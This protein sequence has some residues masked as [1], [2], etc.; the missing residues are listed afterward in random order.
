MLKQS[1]LKTADEILYCTVF[2]VRQK[3]LISA[4]FMSTISLSFSLL[5]TEKVVFFHQ[6]LNNETNDLKFPTWTQ[7]L[8]RVITILL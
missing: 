3:N 1:L 5:S 4:L 2:K 7:R 6:T 8:R